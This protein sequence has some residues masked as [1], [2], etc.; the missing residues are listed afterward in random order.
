V[1]LGAKG[2]ALDRAR[3]LAVAD[4]ATALAERKAAITERDAWKAKA[5]DA[6]AANRAYDTA[7]D[8]LQA[9]AEEQQRLADAA[10]HKA[11]AEV[12]T[13]KRDEA[14]AERELGEYRRTFGARPKDCDAALLALD[15]VCPTLGDY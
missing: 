3:D 13:A 1:G 11:A 2:C 8:Q 12:A 7:F 6:L 9:A 10:A 14:K 4:K 5:A 15:R